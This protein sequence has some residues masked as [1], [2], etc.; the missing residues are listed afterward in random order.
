MATI[1][2][3]RVDA[4]SAD[5]QVHTFGHRAMLVAAG[6]GFAIGVVVT[7]AFSPLWSAVSS[8][9]NASGTV[10]PT[11][12]PLSRSQVLARTTQLANAAL[13][14]YYSTGK[15]RLQNVTIIPDTGGNPNVGELP[16]AYD[17]QITFLLNPNAAGTK[18]QV[19]GAESDTFLVLKGLYAHGLPLNDIS[20]TGIFQFPKQKHASVALRAGSTSVI[21]SKFASWKSLSRSD[22][23]RVWAALRP[24]W[25]SP[26]FQV[27]VPKP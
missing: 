9:H 26:A 27:Y 22:Y 3:G 15:Q 4:V 19:G 24:H 25:M 5:E 13:G 12:I 7:L 17:A 11:P 6:T 1:E 8:H 20:L 16:V 18:Y 14:M 23:K 21:E 10:A 2:S